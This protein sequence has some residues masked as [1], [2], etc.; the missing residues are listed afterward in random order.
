MEV[1]Q[2]IQEYTLHNESESQTQIP[3]GRIRDA[4][5]KNKDQ[6]KLDKILRKRVH[7]SIDDSER[8][9]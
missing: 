3:S 1:T 4:K 2:G 9:V 7:G 5:R 6:Q 8:R